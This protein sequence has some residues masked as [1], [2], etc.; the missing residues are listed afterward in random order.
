V[1]TLCI[2]LKSEPDIHTLDLSGC[3]LTLDGGR[4]IGATLR[5]NQ[6]LKNLKWSHEAP[7]LP[8]QELSGRLAKAK[9]Y[10]CRF[11]LGAL[12]GSIVSE[13]LIANASLSHLDLSCN[14]LGARADV[15]CLALGTAIRAQPPRLV[16][17]SL[18]KNYIGDAGALALADAIAHN[19]VLRKL[20]LSFNEIGE[21]GMRHIATRLGNTHINALGLRGNPV[22]VAVARYIT[23][24]LRSNCAS[25]FSIEM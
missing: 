11:R 6:V 12:A 22:E 15:A 7:P 4:T 20:D 5:D 18:T 21:R 23:E 17:L 13:L 24:L 1:T 3:Q 16:S 10:L 25:L 8:V 14:M 19:S 2:W 9:L